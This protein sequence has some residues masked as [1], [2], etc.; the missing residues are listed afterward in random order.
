MKPREG[1]TIIISFHGDI[2]LA[3]RTALVHREPSFLLGSELVRNEIRYDNENRNGANGWDDF[4]RDNRKFNS[5][6]Y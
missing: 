4:N 1:K 5:I 6:E 3:N 2:P